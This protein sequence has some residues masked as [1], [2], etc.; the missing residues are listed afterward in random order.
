MKYSYIQQYKGIFKTHWTKE[1]DIKQPSAA[2]NDQPIEPYCCPWASSK[3][4]GA[5]PVSRRPLTSL[6]SQKLAFDKQRKGGHLRRS[7]NNWDGCSCILVFFTS[8]HSPVRGKLSEARSSLPV[9]HI[10]GSRGLGRKFWPF[11]PELP[12]F[13]QI[14]PSRRHEQIDIH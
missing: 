10:S 4:V 2:R 3:G 7:G 1:T 12:C 6:A 5:C 9:L 8:S 11:Q 13:L 14:T